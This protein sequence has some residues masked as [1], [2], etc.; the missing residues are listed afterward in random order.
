MLPLTASTRM[1]VVQNRTR[2]VGGASDKTS[3]VEGGQILFGAV[4]F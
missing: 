4:N 2:G 1:H 3:F